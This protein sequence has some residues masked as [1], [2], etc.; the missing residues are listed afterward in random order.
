MPLDVEKIRKDFPILS[1][2]INGKPLTYLDNAATSQ[3]P[4]VVIDALLRHY[5]KFNA[6]V[7]RGVHKLSEEA[8]EQYEAAREKIARFI[9]AD[10]KE[11]VFVRN[12][13]EAINLVARSVGDEL[14]AGDRVVT[15]MMEHH[16]NIVPWQRL[17]GKKVEL[18]YV[19]I[20]D[21]GTLNLQDY[22]RFL[23]R[24]GGG[25]GRA[26]L[27]A[28]T[29]VSNVLGTI[30]PVREMAARAHEAGALVLVDGAQSVPHMPIDVKEMGCDFLAFSGHKM[31]GPTGIGVL[32]GRKKILER[33][34]PFLYGGEMIREVG[35]F[36]TKFNE[37]PWKF[38]AG[39]PNIADA[40]A[41]GVAVDYLT[42]LGMRKVREHEKEL[43]EYAL[44]V[45]SSVN[46]VEIYGPRDVEIRGGVV[47]FNLKGVHAHDLATILDSE[48]I[49][50]RSGHACCQP[51]MARLGVAAVARSS[52]YIYN[53]PGE[54]D[55]LAAGIKK[56]QK[57]FG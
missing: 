16:S 3:K 51:L 22:D 12:A 5:R 53:T 47:S 31:L 21:D 24:G 32:W 11:I 10:P 52:F 30:N 38:E 13:T 6:N 44:E 15:T 35:L 49:A 4:K 45:L 2:K 29:H 8:T 9:N 57:I 48:G 36:E 34:E 27:V 41:L 7:Q 54:I 50:I 14:G 37:V 43:T 33:M 1:R 39:T 19:D 26:G 42:S 20:N 40:I 23:A 56:A 18:R 28:V 17:R 25:A 46:G 55:R